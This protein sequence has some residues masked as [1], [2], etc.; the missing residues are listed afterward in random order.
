MP[1]IKQQASHADA[2]QGR[3]NSKNLYVGSPTPLVI[4]TKGMQYM[5]VWTGIFLWSPV[6]EHIQPGIRVISAMGSGVRCFLWCRLW[7][8]PHKDCWSCG[9]EFQKF[10]FVA[11]QVCL[12]KSCLCLVQSPIVPQANHSPNRTLPLV[13]GREAC[14]V[15]QFLFIHLANLASLSSVLSSFCC[16]GCH[17]LDFLSCSIGSTVFYLGRAWASPTLAWLHCARMCVSMLV[18]LFGPT[19]YRKF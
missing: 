18:C 17:G 19:T 16:V 12:L 15:Q 10:F 4:T 11:Q 3:D 14:R 2:P 1:S 8:N 7:V 6:S 13:V 5:I 9:M